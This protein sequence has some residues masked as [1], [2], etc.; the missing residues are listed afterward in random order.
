MKLFF[1]GIALFILGG[2]NSQVIRI[3]VYQ[4]LEYSEFDTLGVFNAIQ[5][6][7]DE[8][9]IIEA[10]CEYVMDLNNKWSK[11][12]R[13]GVLETES[14]LT[15]QNEG[16]LYA[17]N[18]LYEGFDVGVVFNLDSKNETFDWFSRTGDYYLIS[19]GLKF[20]IVKGS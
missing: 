7:S 1:I 8:T 15:F 20:E 6:V 17:V 13:N 2:L 5:N 4:A 18:F 10:N 14:E 16:S 9:S 3:R 19:K 11:F 12:Y